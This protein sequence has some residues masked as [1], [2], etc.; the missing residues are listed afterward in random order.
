MSA[1]CS[2]PEH[3]KNVG[4][5]RFVITSTCPGDTGYES[6]I[7]NA[8]SLAQTHSAAG[9]ARN[10]EGGAA[11]MAGSLDHRRSDVVRIGRVPSVLMLDFDVH[12]GGGDP[13][14]EPFHD[15]GDDA[16]S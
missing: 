12:G 2:S 10:G 11:S 5:T 9:M 8:R 13:R 16:G 7:A 6:K 4:T 1:D 14:D 3:S 15:G